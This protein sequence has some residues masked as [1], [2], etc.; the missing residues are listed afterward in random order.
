MSN[1]QPQAEHDGY[2]R[3]YEFG[4]EL[5]ERLSDAGIIDKAVQ[6]IVIV[7]ENDDYAMM[8]T[9]AAVPVKLIDE[10]FVRKPGTRKLFQRKVL[11]KIIFRFGWGR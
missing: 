7:I 11:A 10:L 4:P 3:D 5:L 6:Q 9:T 8:Y 1:Y 2:N